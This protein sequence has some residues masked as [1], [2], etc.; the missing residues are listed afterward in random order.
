MRSSTGMKRFV[1]SIVGGLL[2]AVSALALAGPAVTDGSKAAGMDSCVV[3]T[4]EMRRNHMDYLKHDR[5]ETV[6]KGNRD[7]KNSLAE[8]ISCHVSKDGKGGYIPINQEGEFCDSCHSYV[9][10]KP[11]CFQCHATV[12]EAASASL[13]SGLPQDD[14]HTAFTAAEIEQLHAISQE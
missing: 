4:A 6:R 5:I 2:A 14:I 11:A 12:P 8:C 10:I 3:P 7:T 13:N 1:G 9:A